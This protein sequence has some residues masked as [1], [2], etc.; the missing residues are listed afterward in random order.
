MILDDPH[1]PVRRHG[2]NRNILSVSHSLLEPPC[3][4]DDLS[5]QFIRHAFLNIKPLDRRARLAAVAE[6]TPDS[7][8]RSEF[9]V[10]IGKND[11]RVLAAEFEHTGSEIRGC[12]SGD[13]L[14]GSDRASEHYLVRC[15]LDKCRTCFAGAADDLHCIL[16]KPGLFKYLAD[17]EPDERR[18]L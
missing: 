12:G 11:H 7:R 1:L 8:S 3:L 16:R 18:Q 5:R 14:A 13:L 17:L 9:K 2:A 4:L 10:C 15:S 6:R